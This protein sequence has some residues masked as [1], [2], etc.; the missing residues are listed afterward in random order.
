M[1][2]LHFYLGNRGADRALIKGFE[3]GTDQIQL[4]GSES[5][6]FFK[7]TNSGNTNIFFEG[8]QRD[9]VGIVRGCNRT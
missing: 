5:D 4:F 3:V 9:L 1:S 6:Y 8:V 7:E 2:S